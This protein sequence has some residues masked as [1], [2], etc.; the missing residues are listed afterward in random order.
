MDG[1]RNVCMC[2]GQKLVRGEKR[3]LLEEKKKK[4][5]HETC[6]TFLNRWH[7]RMR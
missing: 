6:L 5:I 4:K 3:V 2:V 1:C 7:M